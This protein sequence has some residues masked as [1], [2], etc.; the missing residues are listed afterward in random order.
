MA[1]SGKKINKKR[2]WIWISI[3]TLVIL[4]LIA[5]GQD[6]R[7][8]YLIFLRLAGIRVE[9]IPPEVWLSV[10]V[11]LF[12]LVVGLIV[13]AS[14]WIMLVSAQALLPISNFYEDEYQPK[15]LAT[16]FGEV[17]RV[18]FHL[19]LYIFGSHGPA[20]FIQDGKELSTPE[21]K[22]RSGPGV[23]VI[24]YNS[25]VILEQQLPKASLLMP[26]FTLLR[27][28]TEMLGLRD[29]LE[30][31]P[32]GGFPQSL[33]QRA[34]GPGIVYTNSLERI[35]GV[36]D[37]RKQ[38][39]FAKDVTAHTR[40]GIKLTANGIV[41]LFSVG[42]EAD[43]LQVTFL[44]GRQAENLRAVSVKPIDKKGEILEITP[45]REEELDDED[46][47]I[48]FNSIKEAKSSRRPYQ[49]LPEIPLEPSFNAKRVFEAVAS[50]AARG[51]AE[52]P[53]T[54]LPLQNSIKIFRDLISTYN[55]NLLSLD[56]NETRLFNLNEINERM[57]IQARNSGILS[58]RLIFH[59]HGELL[60][61]GSYPT[62]Q[63]RVSAIYPLPS[64]SKAILRDRG[65]KVIHAGF[66]PM[67]PAFEGV[68]KQRF[69][70]W[71]AK[72]QSEILTSR[73]L[74]GLEARR[75]YNQALAAAQSEM[76]T[77]L[78]EI[79]KKYPYSDE[80]VSLRVLQALENASS[81]PM[82]Q[83]LVASDTINLLKAAYEWLPPPKDDKPTEAKP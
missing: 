78:T 61:A 60:K 44:E 25:A 81:N 43:V 31:P 53:W 22:R 18:A 11:L 13:P 49:P 54:D 68:Y 42:E 17:Y 55:Y 52:V 26:I 34:H 71:H 3:I 2:L 14:L 74:Y 57:K 80:A 6:L 46:R 12:T 35:R 50:Q 40:D 63:I 29:R 7:N 33:P 83:K 59:K 5:F 77:I 4:F 75:T 76:I 23:L 20:I 24:D 8:I 16:R 82:T 37:L 47:L 27:R 72:W 79:F 73:A 67:R 19:L 41:T 62:D 69:D 9:P 38:S 56:P 36:V 70:T 39:R 64:T 48:I 10:F 30:R 1:P 15:S 28:F 51:D 66:L 65:I 21:E 32:E 58:Y 45:L